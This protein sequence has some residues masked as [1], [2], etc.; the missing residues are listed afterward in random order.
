MYKQIRIKDSACEKRVWNSVYTNQL[1]L[2]ATARQNAKHP[3]KVRTLR[4]HACTACG[5]NACPFV[6]SYAYMQSMPLIHCSILAFGCTSL[7]RILSIGLS[8]RYRFLSES[9][10][11]LSL[12]SVCND[13]ICT[14]FTSFN[15]NRTS[16]KVH[17]G[18]RTLHGSVSVCRAVSSVV[19]E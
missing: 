12:A 15:E 8:Q 1:L 5:S 7:V 17:S 14:R 4:T 19:F 6:V 18:V 2:D 11:F 16:N 9:H 10:I 13:R 3:M